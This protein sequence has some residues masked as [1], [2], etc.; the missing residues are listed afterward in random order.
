MVDAPLCPNTQSPQLLSL[1]KMGKLRGQYKS[2]PIITAARPS[3][4]FLNEMASL[5]CMKVSNTQKVLLQK[6]PHASDFPGLK[7]EVWLVANGMSTWLTALS[8]F[9]FIEPIKY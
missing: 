3:K 9:T 1:Y 7:E 5:A 4:M 2:V 8:I 6:A